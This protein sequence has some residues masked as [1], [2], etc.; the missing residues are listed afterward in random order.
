M[1]RWLTGDEYDVC[2]VMH[3]R[4]PVRVRVRVGVRVRVRVG[5]RVRVRESHVIRRVA[6]TR[7]EERGVASGLGEILTSYPESSTK[8][9][10][11]SECNGSIFLAM[12]ATSVSYHNAPVLSNDMAYMPASASKEPG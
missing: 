2:N 8:S 11:L 7:R 3:Q 12:M 1:L 4:D 5:V 6:S 9:E 10:R